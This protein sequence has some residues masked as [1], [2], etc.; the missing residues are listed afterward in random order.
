MR[1][2]CQR[3]LPAIACTFLI[4]LGTLPPVSADISVPTKTTVFFEQDAAPFTGPVT[5]N[6]SCYGYLCRDYACRPD[7]AYSETDPHNA[8]LVFSYSASCPQYGC[9]IYEPFY[10]NHRHIAW[11]DM[12]G[13][14]NGT[15]FVIPRYAVNPLPDCTY[16]F[17]FDVSENDTYYRYPPGYR[18]CLE[19]N[20]QEKKEVCGKFITPVTWAEIENQTGL[21]WFANN[22]T[23]WV[24]TDAYFSCISQIENA[25]GSCGSEY[26]LQPV[27]R[28]DLERAPGGQIIENFCT[29]RVALPSSGTPA[30]SG[31]DHPGQ[32]SP[33]ESDGNKTPGIVPG[34]PVTTIIRFSDPVES[35]WCSLLQ[36]FGGRC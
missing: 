7:R 24:R 5:F 35:L 19:K 26:P 16:R 17:P 12:A 14:A 21:S 13:T 4:L 28:S 25:A 27:N 33:Q 32:Q 8:A 20:E 10:L 15:A 22:G 2:S 34:K 6:V 29:L 23:Y 31:G 36:L 30:L 18:A 1:I 3:I 9:A 11:C